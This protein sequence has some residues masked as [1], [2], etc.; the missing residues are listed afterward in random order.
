MLS[1]VGVAVGAAAARPTK[2]ATKLMKCISIAD[3]A[4]GKKIEKIVEKKNGSW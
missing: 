2:T 1:L 4:D 3:L